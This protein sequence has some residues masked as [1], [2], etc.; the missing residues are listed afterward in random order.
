ML[1]IVIFSF[2]VYIQSVYATHLSESTKQQQQQ[3]LL[4]IFSTRNIPSFNPA[5]MTQQIDYAITK[6]NFGCP[7][8]IAIYIHGFNKDQNDAE[9]FNR[10]QMSLK[11]NNYTIPII[12]FSWNSKTE[13]DKA[14][15]N[16]INSGGELTK[17][18]IAFKN[19][20]PNT[21][22]HIIA[23]SLGAA[24]VENTL[25]NLDF[26]LNSNI[27]NDTSKIIKS[28]HL[29]GAAIDNKLIADNTTF[30]NAIEHSVENFY[31]LFNSQDDG[32][33]FNKN[34]EKHEPLGLVGAPY[35]K[36]PLNYNDKNV[37][38]ELP[39]I[40]YAD[41]DG[42]LEECFED[43]YKPVLMQGDNHCGY[44]GFRQPFSDSLIHDGDGVINIVVEDWKKS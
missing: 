10:I 9:E 8:E 6:F 11:H 14:K 40:S 28:V 24:V 5:Q 42:N 39:L 22:I 31:N 25:N 41:G 1:S 20:C 16:A 27:S 13:W 7:S 3:P 12:G 29:L 36:I 19:K 21:N 37:T 34:Y 35:M 15:V 18:I 4:Y 30:G 38:S 2:A 32:L 33:E 44:I 43:I 26:Y 17:F 23:H